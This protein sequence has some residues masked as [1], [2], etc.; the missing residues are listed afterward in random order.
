MDSRM[1]VVQNA[2]RLAMGDH[3]LANPVRRRR[4]RSDRFYNAGVLFATALAV[5]LTVAL[6]AGFG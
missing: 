3:R 4:Q 1:N 2:A 5:V 6:L